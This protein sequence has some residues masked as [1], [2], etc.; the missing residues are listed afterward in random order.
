MTLQLGNTVLAL[1]I[2]P[3]LINT[4]GIS[5]YGLYSFAFAISMYL[6]IVTDYGF[7]FT[8]VKLISVN[9]NNL[10]KV[11]G[12]FHSIQIIKIIILLILLV[13][14]SLAIL[15]IETLSENKELFFLSFGILIGQTIIP[16]WFFQGMEKMKYITVINLSIR[17]IS[18][19][20]ILVFV[21]Q[22]EDINLAIASQAFG[23]L[24]A[25]VLSVF[26]A[27]AK[28][29]LKPSFPKKT[30]VFHLLSSSKD[31]FFSSLSLSLYKNFNLIFLGFLSTNTEV[32][33]YSAAEKIIKA[34]HSLTAPLSQ[35]IYPNMSLKFSELKTNESVSKLLKLSKYYT[36]PLLGIISLLLLFEDFFIR[37]LG[38]SDSGFSR[39]FI[40]LTP[41]IF[42]GSLNYLFGIIGLVNLNKEKNFNK[43][44]LTGAAVNL[45]LCWL[46]SEN[47][48]A[49]GSAI[50][51]VIAEFTVLLL[52]IYF[53]F[54]IKNRKN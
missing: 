41:V 19:I 53:L 2:M 22:P 40:V 26:I 8:G 3:Y 14:Y 18:L 32:G 39:V 51:L 29:D 52:V 17:L 42:L 15:F 28:F 21:K 48:G 13:I 7:G 31:M 36:V 49:T 1:I 30:D 20:L 44:T 12:I 54:K 47:Y 9:R 43:A 25:G 37:F 10:N 38:I 11:S 23:F 24:F 5:K 45:T 6:V 27:Y 46:L 33:I 4:L 35:A 50:A 16:I 34:A